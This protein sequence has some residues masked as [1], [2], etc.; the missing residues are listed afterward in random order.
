MVP[1]SNMFRCLKPQHCAGVL[2]CIAVHGDSALTDVSPHA[3]S[4]CQTREFWNGSALKHVREQL[5]AHDGADLGFTPD[6]P[7]PACRSSSR[8]TQPVD[9]ASSPVPQAQRA[10]VP[11]PLARSQRSLQPKIKTSQHSCWIEPPEHSCQQHPVRVHPSAPCTCST[12]ERTASLEF[13]VDCTQVMIQGD[14]MW[15]AARVQYAKA[16]RQLRLC[17]AHSPRCERYASWATTGTRTGTPL[18]AP[19]F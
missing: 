4:R 8:R 9:I 3:T 15:H 5:I 10:G 17:I 2:H 11:D 18:T 14:R 13:A 6:S 16:L 19:R 1:V 12:Y 7:A